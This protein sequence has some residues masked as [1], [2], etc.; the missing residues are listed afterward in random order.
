MEFLSIPDSYYDI[1]RE[2]LSKSNVKVVEEFKTL[3]VKKNY[4][5]YIY[6]LFVLKVV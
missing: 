5:I 1:L 3:Q 2:K 4:D 6:G